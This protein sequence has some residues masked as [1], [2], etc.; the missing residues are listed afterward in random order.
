MKSENEFARQM[1]KF[2]VTC[3]NNVYMA[4]FLEIKMLLVIVVQDIVDKSSRT[5]FD[6][7][8]KPEG[9]VQ[10]AVSF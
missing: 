4:R 10:S 8:I 7:C 3:Q 9:Y 6:M 2:V 1:R 5:E